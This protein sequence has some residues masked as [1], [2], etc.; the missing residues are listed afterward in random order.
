MHVRQVDDA[1]G[2]R[3]P[4]AQAVEVV[5][6]AAMHVG[7]GTGERGR[8]RIGTSETDH[9]VPCGEQLGGDGRS[10]VAGRTGDEH[11]HEDLPFRRCR[12]TQTTTARARGN[13]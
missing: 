6:G 11:T 10:D 8:R 1:V 2:T 4:R 9:L 13:P 3:R 7:A 5:E 12:G